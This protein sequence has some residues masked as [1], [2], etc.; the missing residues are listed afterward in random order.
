MGDTARLAVRVSRRARL[1]AFAGLLAA[2]AGL[3]GGGLTFGDAEAQQAP[4]TPQGLAAIALDGRANLA[5]KATTGATS[6]ALYRGT[7]P[8]AITTRV[9]PVGHTAR[10]YTDLGRTNGTTY[11]YAVRSV[12]SGIE[13]APSQMVSVTPRARSCSSSNIVVNE[14]CF[15]GT[16]A[17]K[18]ANGTRA[19]DGGIEG[20]ASASSVNQGGSVDLRVLTDWNAPYHIEIYRSGHYGG[21]QGR[22]ISV[23]PGLSGEWQP[24]C[25][26]EPDTTG[27]I[28]CAGWPVETSI[29]TS[30]SWPSGVYLL[31]LVREDNG[32]SSEIPLVVRRDG[33]SS[34][35]LYH[36]PTST[37]QA[38][39]RFEGK[40]LYDGQSD[41]P[42]T[43]SGAHRAVKVS[44]D[45]PYSQPTESAGA[46]D[47]YTRT[48]VGTVSWLEQQG[49]DTTYIASEDFHASGAQ[50]RRHPVFVSGSHDEYWS[51]NM[52]NQAI[53]ARNA[54]TSLVFM[55]A[56]AA[57]WRVRFEAS[58]VSG[59]VN[60]VMVVYKT[61]QS[62]PPDPSGSPTTTWRDPAGPNR[63]ENELIGQMYVG[64]NSLENFPLRVS[65]G[66]GANRIW[67]YASPARL[68]AGQA[69]TLGS[70]L[71]GWEWDA[72][73]ANG[74]EPAG[75]ATVASS[76]VSGGLVQE[77]GRFQTQGTTSATATI[78]RAASGAYVFAS[79]T[80]NWW[81][82]LAPNVHG[83][84]EPNADVK[85]LMA[86]VLSDMGVRAPTPAAGL[87]LD[88][89]GAPVVSSTVPANGATSV[90]PN[91]E[92]SVRFDRELDPASVDDAHFTLTPSSGPSLALDA[93]LDNATKTVTLRSAVALE[94]FTAY[95]A[96]VGTGLTAWNGTPLAAPVSWSF[97]TGPGTPPLLTTR[98]PAAGAVGVSTDSAVE[99]GFDRRLDPAS[100]TASSFLLRPSG[101]GP[102]CPPS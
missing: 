99:A 13:S 79:G 44:F 95:T 76:P 17:W 22:L 56:N 101:E 100:V 55:G 58:A 96:T 30:T 41:P 69:A 47:W 34:A 75:V 85:Q 36:V 94:P 40:S 4:G 84:G 87:Q 32:T 24:G 70:E 14:N 6:Y 62:G 80:N 29:T 52:F 74:R 71:V 91:A 3:A 92:L 93:T 19:H 60:R 20:Y 46:H 63:P 7:S 50:L 67:R 11:F 1:L 18:T 72:R 5:W 43:V 90:L 39:N 59:A 77:N 21:S 23:L 45:R 37:Y 2:L 53:A 61:V 66:E 27:L 73:V 64:D 31:K 35:L 9:T 8:A 83:Q 57:Y 12:T 65:A 38:Y 42:N 28:D 78:Y 26:K 82:G 48:D 98:T 33:S 81:R 97:T 49:Y 51:Q 86:N 68:G 10:S 88:P 25:L 89:L 102:R 15:P 54:G 16:T